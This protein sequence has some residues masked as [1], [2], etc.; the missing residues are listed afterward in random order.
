MKFRYIA[1]AVLCVGVLLTIA[2]LAPEMCRSF[3]WPLIFDSTGKF[4]SNGILGANSGRHMLSL[5]DL[6]EFG[7]FTGPVLIIAALP[8]CFSPRLGEKQTGRWSLSLFFAGVGCTGMIVKMSLPFYAVPH[9]ASI[10]PMGWAMAIFGIAVI[11]VISAI[12]F[13]F[14]AF[15]RD[16]RGWILWSGLVLCLAPFPT[17]MAMLTHAQKLNGFELSQ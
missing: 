3:F 14:A 15:K 13:G 11:G 2:S 10:R 8:F 9:G 16:R 5:Y 1:I 12:I 4:R 7:W 17:G 6:I